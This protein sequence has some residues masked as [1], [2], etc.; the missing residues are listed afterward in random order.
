MTATHSIDVCNSVAIGLSS[1]LSLTARMLAALILVLAPSLVIELRHLPGT[2]RYRVACSA[3]WFTLLVGEA[4]FLP[5]DSPL[6][7]LFEI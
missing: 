1:I 5:A 3:K 7:R 6:L 4:K 2:L